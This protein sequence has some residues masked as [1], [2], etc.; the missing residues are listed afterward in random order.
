MTVLLALVSKWESGRKS[1]PGG[2]S[3]AVLVAVEDAGAA[4]GA[5]AG[6]LGPISR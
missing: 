4:A 3:P 2:Q 5:I 6:L 1:D